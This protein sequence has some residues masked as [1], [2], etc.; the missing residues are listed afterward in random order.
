MKETING[1]TSWYEDDM[2]P[3]TLHRE[4]GPAVE[5]Y[6]GFK[7][8]Y[9]HGERHREDGPAV[10]DINGSF[11]WFKHGKRHREDGPATYTSDRESELFS[12]SEWWFNDVKI[13]C[14]SQEEFERL[15][16]LKAF[17]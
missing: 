14:S 16:N 4:D 12:T 10:E 1:N 3:R 2:L 8:W 17:W 11:H 9:F 7:E 5:W 13:N 6:D 15:I